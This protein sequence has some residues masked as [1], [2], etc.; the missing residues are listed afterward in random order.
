MIIPSQTQNLK[1]KPKWQASV[2]TME[3]VVAHNCRTH[4]MPVPV[5]A[6]P[7]WELAGNRV[8]D[9]SGHGNHGLF[10]NEQPGWIANGLDFSLHTKCKVDS[11]DHDSLD[12]PDNHTI[13]QMARW[14]LFT[15]FG[16]LNQKGPVATT[17]QMNYTTWSYNNNRIIS[18]VGNGTSYAIADTG[19]IPAILTLGKWH[20]IISELDETDL[21]IYIN[22]I[23][24]A[25]GTRA[26]GDAYVNS[27]P[28]TVGN[29]YKNQSHV[30]GDI[31]YTYIF[32]VAL[33]AQQRSFIYDNPYF[34]FRL[35]EELYGYTAGAPPTG[36]IMQQFQKSNLGSHLYNGGIII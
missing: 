27:D 7:F 21:K 36:A 3:S 8:Y 31:A 20:Q 4:G 18:Y 5:L 32:N 30:P 17:S 12:L 24:R 23:E 26:S 29:G 14:N 35:P 1:V 28:V 25:T 9:L 11:P 34:M 2:G 13:V 15:D 16:V 33:S 19:L 10:D 22:N 6:M